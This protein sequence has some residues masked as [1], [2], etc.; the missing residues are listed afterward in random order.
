MGDAR[1]SIMT[2]QCSPHYLNALMLQR[3]CG[4]TQKYVPC[5]FSIDRLRL[6]VAYY[7]VPDPVVFL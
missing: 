2:L 1:T 6:S 4:N 3:F 7:R 5:G